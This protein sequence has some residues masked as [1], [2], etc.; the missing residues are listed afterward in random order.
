MA[1]LSLRQAT[2]AF[3]VSRQTLGKALKDGTVSGARDAAGNWHIDSAE[4]QRVYQPREPAP[5]PRTPDRTPDFTTSAMPETGL[6]RGEASAVT[7]ARLQAELSAERELRAAD[8]AAERAKVEILERY[9]ADVRLRLPPP[10]APP[11]RR[12]WWPFG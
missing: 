2:V 8:V 6:G 12:R 10:D 9:L 5:P 7:I 11:P 3:A 4:L 1:K